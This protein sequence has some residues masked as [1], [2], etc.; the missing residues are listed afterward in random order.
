MKSPNTNL[1]SIGDQEFNGLQEAHNYRFLFYYEKHSVI[2]TEQAQLPF[3]ST[4]YVPRQSK[5]EHEHQHVNPELWRSVDHDVHAILYLQTGVFSR[6]S[7]RSP[8]PFQDLICSWITRFCFFFISKIFSFTP[9][10]HSI[11]P[12]AM[13]IPLWLLTVRAFHQFSA[14][15]YTQFLLRSRWRSKWPLSLKEVKDLCLCKVHSI[16]QISLPKERLHLLSPLI[17]TQNIGRL[18][19]LFKRA[20]KMLVCTGKRKVEELTGIRYSNTLGPQFLV[21]SSFIENFKMLSNNYFELLS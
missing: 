17:S 12:D 16:Y 18:L 11:I 4:D 21:G 14:V 1:D 5:K 15:T 3:L 19:R 20:P 13:S 7:L 9:S 2:L 8:A 6:A 10:S